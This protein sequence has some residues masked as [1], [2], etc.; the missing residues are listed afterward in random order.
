MSRVGRLRFA[1]HLDKNG[2]WQLAVGARHAGV[3]DNWQEAQGQRQ[4]QNRKTQLAHGAPGPTA[5]N[6]EE[7]TGHRPQATGKRNNKN[8]Q[9]VVVVSS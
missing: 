2:S 4:Q 1:P 9:Y 3:Y 8:R 7:A 6:R 5:G